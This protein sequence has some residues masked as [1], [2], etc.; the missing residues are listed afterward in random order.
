MLEGYHLFVGG[1]YGDEQ[2]I[3]RELFRNLPFEDVPPT[4]YRLVQSYLDRRADSQETFRDYVRRVSKEDLL[5]HLMPS[6]PTQI[7]VSR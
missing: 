4:I 6:T 7:P 3:G 5:Q 1:G 2:G